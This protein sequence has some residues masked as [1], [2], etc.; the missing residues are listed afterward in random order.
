MSISVFAAAPA[1][2][3]GKIRPLVKASAKTTNN[4]FFIFFPLSSFV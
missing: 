4:S 2:V 1:W 3:G